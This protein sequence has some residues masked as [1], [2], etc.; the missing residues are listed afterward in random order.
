[1]SRCDAGTWSYVINRK[2]IVFCRF[3]YIR[4]TEILQSRV[5]SFR[6][7]ISSTVFALKWH[8]LLKQITGREEGRHS[9]INVNE[10]SCYVRTTIIV[11][12]YGLT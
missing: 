7:R 2:I 6:R 3:M 12:R 10:F 8:C 4:K 11:H 9:Q 1:M 5:T